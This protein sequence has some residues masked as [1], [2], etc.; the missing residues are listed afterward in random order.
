V[1]KFFFL[2]PYVLSFAISIG[3]LVYTLQFRGVR[4]ASAYA[5]YVAG[6]SLWV[7]GYIFELIS[8]SLGGKIFWDKSQ[9]VAGIFLAIAFPVFAIQ[10]TEIKFSRL[11]LLFTLSL[12]IPLS[13]LI[14]LVTDSQHHLIYPN[15]YLDHTNIFS[16]LKYDFTWVIYTYA[17]YSYLV[18][19]TGLGILIKRLIRPHRL[20][21][22]QI[23]TVAV[24]FFIPIFFTM[25][26]TAGVKFMPFRDVSPIT[27]AI[28]N[29]IVAWGLFRYH[30]FDIIPIA[31][32]I[33]V[34]N[35]E[36]LV[37]VL[38]MQER[39]VDIN[40]AA[41]K[42][43]DME[44]S[45]V[46]GQSAEKIFNAWPELMERFYK[47]ESIKTEISLSSTAEPVHFEIKSTVLH[48]KNK[49]YIGRVFVS[50]D[51]TE[52]VNLQKRLEKL[53]K[54]LEDRVRVRTEELRKS[55][56]RYRAVVENQ[57]EFIVRWRLDGTRTFVNDA[58]RNYFGIT[59]ELATSTSFIPLVA[60]EDRHAVNEKIARLMSGEVD[61]ET[62]I[63]R[64]INPGG[65]IGWQEWTDRVIRDE[66][67][68]V[69]EFQ[70]VGRDITMRKQAEEALRESES[71]Y[72]QAIEVA[73]AVPYRQSYPEEG[74]HVVYD[75]IG[76][77]I[78]KITGYGPEEFNATLW[79]SLVQESHLL[80][81][82]AEYSFEEAI[83]RVRSGVNSIWLCEHRIKN[84]NGEVRWVYEAAVELRDK[85][86]NS[87]GSIGLY[88]DI[89]EQKQ[90]EIALQE[91]E[92]KHRL[93]FEAANDSIFLMLGEHFVDCNSKTL[94][95]FGCQ[96][97]QIIGKTP[98]DFSP[99]LQ[100]DG[101]LSQEKARNK[102]EGVLKGKPQF[103]EWKHCRLDKTPF[104]A[105]VSLNPLMLGNEIYIQAIVRDI[106]ERKQAEAN[107]M[108]AYDTTLEGWARALELR[109]KETEDHSRRVTD[110]TVTLAKAMGLQ[111]EELT[112]VRRG[113]IL[114]DIGK[115]GIPDEILRKRGELTVAERNIVKQH[116]NLSLELLSP[117]PFLRQALDIP[118][119]HHERWDGTGYPRGLKGEDI[120][121]S[122][123][124]F[125]VIDVWDALLSDRPYSKAWPKEKTIRYLKEQAGKHFDPRI[126]EVFLNL[127]D[128]GAI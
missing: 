84:R 37:V 30:L 76:E 65:S 1:N 78:R 89:T 55:A 87:H 119:C 44:A 120:P 13:L 121:L 114:H 54:E 7:F 46:I 27:F 82:L 4:G 41:L 58:Y 126:V 101:Q 50:R 15:P 2:L 75:F 99:D 25:L 123:R 112:H 63:H 11:R 115:M 49:R 113:A 48:D 56:E 35:M 97:E 68:K 28:G 8:P 14:L 102:I 34:E 31:R 16:D 92:E 42:A 90:A 77:G 29:L 39:V 59:S 94:E 66:S 71:I 18:T 96:R 21:R 116:P 81:D 73:G 62:D 128:Q 74:V 117:I 40:S 118:Y 110:L 6:Q 3:V 52:R 67:G 70:S 106:T 83:Q 9:W 38:D 17:I 60:E 122:A 104:D 61:A 72:R 20:Y 107:L 79:D 23:S 33:V 108:E 93:L 103:F 127:V 100:P 12:I 80:E 91:S 69:V 53:N 10:Y 47:P 105:E 51:I 64:V 19:F 98:V 109:D 57:T 32:D 86:G 43:L 111:G 85:D 95:M 36:D 125:S 26:T 88:Q 124:I 24:G 45:Q 22:R 5:W